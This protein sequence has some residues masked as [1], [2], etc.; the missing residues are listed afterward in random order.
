MTSFQSRLGPKEWLRPYTDETLR[1]LAQ[2]GIR[3]VDVVCPGFSADCL[4]TLEEIAMENR[5]NFL[6]AGGDRYT[7]I[8]CLNDR[9]DHIDALC[10]LIERHIQ[11]WPEGALDYDQAAAEKARTRRF[12]LAESMGAQ[13]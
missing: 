12:R 5:D 2:R 8:P 9:E 4:E 10:D 3:Q 1:A 11:G 6:E 7:Y 13:A